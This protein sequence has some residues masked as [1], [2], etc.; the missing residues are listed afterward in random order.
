[1]TAIL[2]RLKHFFEMARPVRPLPEPTAPAPDSHTGLTCLVLV[3]LH[4]GLD[5]KMDEQQL[6]HEYALD[7]CEPTI[8]QLARMADD[9]GM[10]YRTVPL[11]WEKALAME[12]AYPVLCGKRSG[13]YALL[14]GVRRL[15]DEPPELAVIDPLPEPEDAS[16]TADIYRFWTRASFEAFASGEGMLLQKRY[17]LADEHQPFGLRWFIPEF[18]KLKGLFGQIA[19]AVVAMTLLSLLTPLFFQI[20]IDKVLPNSSFT[21]LNVLGI[22][23][24]LAILFNAGLE[25]LRNYLLLFAT[26]KIDINTAT[27]TFAH[28]MRLPVSF[29]DAVP[30][31]LLIK[32]MQQ[33][34]KIRGFLSG[35]LFFTLLDMASLVLFIPFLM[36]Y[37]VPLT[38]IVLGFSLL[39][40]LVIMAL[41]K[42]FQR[43]LDILYQAEGKRQSRLVE[44]LHGIHTVKSLA[45][46]PVEER[47]WNNASAFSIQSHFNVGKIS[48]SAH[49]LSQMLEMLMNVA[50][51]WV[52]AHLVFDHVISIGALIAFQML[53]GRVSGPL[54]KVVGLIH[55]YQQTALSV[56]ML[57]A[58]MNSPQEH[59]GGGVRQGI[60]GQ[61]AFDHVT[62]RYQPDLPEVL[63]DV[64]LSIRAGETV[65]IVGRS[66][67]G[68]S[69]LARLLQAMYHPQSGLIKID[70]IDIREMDKAYL[71]SSIGVVLQ[72][73]YFFQGS[74]RD[75]IR[76]T[77]RDASPEAIL[78]A[79][80]LAGSHDFVSELPRGY[81]TI[82]EENASN[83][84][85]GQKQRLAIA[86]ALLSDPAI[87]ILDEATSALD[88]ES[89]QIIQRNLG[90]IAQNRT[91]L[92]I[93]HR[94]SM[95]RRADTILVIDKGQIAASAPHD[96]LVHRDGLYQEFWHQ[97]MG[98]P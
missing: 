74:I 27:K 17:R 72:D 55:E 64:S 34:E 40:A 22:G 35:S 63:R 10:R 51:I 41:I 7:A 45:L 33:T 3:G 37:S 91:V 32:H 49:T 2:S 13:K 21:T 66:G 24:T 1:M 94:L 75:N 98:M 62:F 92:I 60:Q 9:Y 65:G 44:S 88:P 38:G 39:M 96:I 4:H 29:F 54:V 70:G 58:V 8:P 16:A 77:K 30:S 76:L 73:N 82:L 19:I 47:E 95:A 42:P 56:K 20:V 15:P 79:S 89:E 6:A 68:K 36:L 46:E 26:N 83:L 14:A 57:G 52:G 71:R 85:G 97:Q 69:T 18:L 48:L 11:T 25:F 50:V 12:G 78:E 61:I 87:L 86:R 84:S 59:P 93:T 80:M 31:G 28:L 43:R 5:R 53:S 81:D 23:I 90:N 67:S